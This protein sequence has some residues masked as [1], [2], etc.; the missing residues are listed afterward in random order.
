MLRG[1]DWL[2]SLMS[3]WVSFG[4]LRFQGIRSFHLGYVVES[5]GAELFITQLC[6][7]FNFHGILYSV[8]SLISDISNLCPIFFFPLRFFFFFFF[9]LAWAE[10]SP[11]K[12]NFAR[13]TLLGLVVYFS[14]NTLNLSLQSLLGCLVSEM[15]DVILLFLYRSL[16][17]FLWLL[18]GFFLYLWLTVF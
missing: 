3:S 18:L 8:P 5:V 10:A 4:R 13:Q 11:L 1:I 14:L 9:S 6:H 16:I 17:F 2:G 12:D 7:P 15:L